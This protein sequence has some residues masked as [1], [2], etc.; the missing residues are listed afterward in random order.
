MKALLAAKEDQDPKGWQLFQSSVNSLKLKRTGL[1]RDAAKLAIEAAV[2]D[3]ARAAEPTE[4]EEIMSSSRAWTKGGEG[5]PGVG[6]DG[7]GAAEVDGRLKRDLVRIVL[8]TGFESFNVDLY[9]R[10]AVQLSRVCP[11]ITVQVFSDRDIEPRKVDVEAALSVADVFF[12]SLLFDFDQVEWL[13]E[14]INR[15]PYR[16]IFESALEL[17]SY[18]K[19]GNFKMAPSGK[20]AGPPPAVKKLLGLFGSQKEEDRMVGYL[21]FLKIG[22]QLLKFLPGRKARELRIWLTVYSYWNQGGLNNVVSMF[23]YLVRE[24]FVLTSG[25]AALKP[26]PVIETPQT[27]CLHPAAPGRYFRS[28][29][30]YIQWYEEHGPIR[31]HSAAP[32]VA[33]LLYRKHVITDQPYIPQLIEEMEASG[34]RPLPIFINGVEAHTVVRDQLTTSYEQRMIAEGEARPS[35]LQWNAVPV[36]A[37]V[38]TIGFPL[39]GGPAGTMEGGRQ[40]EIAKGILQSKNVP[41][42]VAAPLLI[43]DLQS[44]IS[45]GIAGLQSVV[46]YSLPE[47]DGAIDTVPLGGLVGDNIFLIPERV[48]RLASRLNQWIKLRRTPPSERRLAIVL[49]GFPPG[50]GSAGTAALLNVPRSLEALLRELRKE[51]YDL[52]DLSEDVKGEDLIAALRDHLSS[53]AIIARG[54]RG[55]STAGS[56]PAE[57]HGAEVEAADVSPKRL[58]ELLTFPSRWGPTEWGPIPFLPEADVLV[59]RMEHQWGELG[60]FRAGLSTSANGDAVIIGLSF[61]NVFVGVQP[62]LGLE[63]DPMRLLFERD[64]T[65]HPQ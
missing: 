40:S 50:V 57:K 30:D 41:Y 1:E 60:K 58:K 61:G 23:E 47:L 54:S 2:A 20:S 3:R 15:I 14:R 17:M 45:D 7:D 22:P 24:C 27:G 21:S 38:N 48:R 39:V 9:K 26:Q 31:K 35:S 34:I 53:E 18:T 4:Y 51:G 32:T 10:V 16:F 49:Y 25:Q 59:Q 42:V 8:I 13:R 65:P 11:N 6:A 43:Q 44:W 5:E 28:P 37:V 62:L 56:G 64:L 36:D 33:L 29:S 52:G 55:A 46:L 12:G 19:V 63:G